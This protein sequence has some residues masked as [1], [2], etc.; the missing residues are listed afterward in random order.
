MGRSGQAGILFVE[1]R[2]DA[3]PTIW[4]EVCDVSVY[5][6][7]QYTARTNMVANQHF[8]RLKHI[9]TDTPSGAAADEIAI[10]YGRAEL[11]GTVNAEPAGAIGEPTLHRQLLSDAA[12]LAA[13][14]LE[15]EHYVTT[16]QFSIDVIDP[17]YDGAVVASAEVVMVEA[18]RYVV[19]AM[20]LDDEGEPVAEARGVFRASE[21]DLPP[22][23]S[24]EKE[25]DTSPSTPPASFAP[26]HTTPYGML[27]LN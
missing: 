22:D 26:V 14:S 7:H 11:N 4:P 19:Q 1:Y 3:W 16:E 25:E 23:P 12:A 9:Y 18:P 27:C 24:P 2:G 20:M 10:A 17:E 5:C 8:Q 13:G 15:K 21:N 6:F